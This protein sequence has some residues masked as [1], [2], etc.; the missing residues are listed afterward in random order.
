MVKRKGFLPILSVLLGL[1][2]LTSACAASG[3]Q[4][5][6]QDQERA[7]GIDTE[8]AKLT[9]GLTDLLDSHVYLA[10]ISVEQAVLTKD[11]NS[12]QFKAAASALDKNSR[13]LAGAIESVYGKD[14]SRQFLKLWRQHI[15]FFVQYTVGG[16]T[17]DQAAQRA[18]K[19]RLDK[20]RQ[21]FGAFIDSA[22]NGELPKATVAG[23]LQMHVNSLLETID[24]VIEGKG[25]PFAK[26]YASSH[27]HMPGTASAL[28]K[29]IIAANPDKF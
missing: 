20:Y 10:G 18:A 23:A 7:S 19:S 29:G 11:A 25:N 26:L 17:G 15:N 5:A 24:S 12:P 6:S 9:Q 4:Q 27:M 16:I 13:D 22:T 14:A 21:D 2:V 8:A 1:A 28:A 3:E